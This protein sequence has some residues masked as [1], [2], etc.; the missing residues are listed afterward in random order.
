MTAT[1]MRCSEQLQDAT[2]SALQHSGFR[3]T[4]VA[5]KVFSLLFALLLSGDI[6]S[7]QAAPPEQSAVFQRVQKVVLPRLEFREASVQEAIDFL[8]RKGIELGGG[9]DKAIN[10]NYAGQQPISDKK[11]TCTFANIPLGE[12]LQYVAHVSG[13]RIGITENGVYLYPPAELP[14]LSQGLREVSWGADAAKEH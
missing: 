9:P 10:I 6:A 5:M 3:S 4:H 8:R 13:L 7:A 11:I 12:V 14:V 2:D 1:L